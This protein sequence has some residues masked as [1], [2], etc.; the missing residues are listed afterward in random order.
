[1]KELNIF[2][3]DIMKEITINVHMKNIKEF[4]IRIWIG[5]WL[6]KL[7]CKIMG[8]RTKDYYDYP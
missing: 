3:R 7:A 6:I 2:M 8:V 1:M 5:A 4:R